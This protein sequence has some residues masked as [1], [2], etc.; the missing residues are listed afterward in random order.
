RQI[1]ADLGGEGFFGPHLQS[2][3][4]N[5]FDRHRLTSAV[6]HK[7]IADIRSAFNRFNQ[8]LDQLIAAYG[9]L[10]IEQKELDP[11]VCEIG[12]LIP[13][14]AVHDR[15]REFMTELNSINK[16]LGVF[17]EIATGSRP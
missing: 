11:N 14:A 5:I 17:S 3:L 6:A 16:D 8:A 9:V 13:R 10:N 2:T 15:L 1:V 4:D 7:E 12:L